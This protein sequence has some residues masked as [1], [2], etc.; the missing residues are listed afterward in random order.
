MILDAGS[1][2]RSTG[3]G[4]VL[5][6]GFLG[7]V[8]VSFVSSAILM[9]RF[10]SGVGWL[11]FAA[12]AAL[13]AVTLAV[14]FRFQVEAAEP[15]WFVLLNVVIGITGKAFYVSLGPPDGVDFLLRGLSPADLLPAALVAT[16]GMSLLALGYLVG[17][18]RWKLPAAR[19]LNAKEWGASRFAIVVLALVLVGVVSFV[20]FAARVGISYEGLGDLSSKRFVEL[21]DTTQRGSL[22]YLRW[23]AAQLEIAFYLVFLRWAHA[24]RRLFTFSGATVVLLGLLALV[25]PFFTSSRWTILMLVVRVFLI[26]FCLG[27]RV[28]PV[29]AVAMMLTGMMLLSSM[30]AFRRN[31]SDWAGVWEHLGAEEL[32]QATVGRRHFLD[33]SKTAHI[34]EAVPDT[35]ELQYGKTL[36]SWLVAPVPRSSWPGKPPIR[37]GADLGLKIFGQPRS[38]VPPGIVA[39]LYLNFS[40]P[41]VFMGLLVVGVFLRSLYVSFRPFFPN[42]AFVLIYTLLA[43]RLGLE[44]LGTSVSGAIV[45]SLQDLAPVLLCLLALGWRHAPEKPAQFE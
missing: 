14:L 34:I 36:I 23:G 38:G 40:Y 3:L 9:V 33:L 13:L 8:F 25:F 22:G 4:R 29:H 41:G 43:T 31:V 28:R 24:G 19:W 44:M 39:D 5:P 42:P 15:I 32:L 26:W 37:Q 17:A 16:T 10:G 2:A 21:Q 45:R 7:L 35:L 1:T 11:C 27:R 20:V 6:L 18:I 30:L 12:S